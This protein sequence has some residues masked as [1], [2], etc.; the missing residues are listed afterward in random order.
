VFDIPLLFEGNRADEFDAVL[1]VSAPAEEQRE[2]ALAR[3]GMTVDKFEAILARQVPDADKCARADYVIP[4]GG[5]LDETRAAVTMA[6]DDLKR[7]AKAGL[8]T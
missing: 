1:V 4:T 5:S 8:H 2:R 7:Q 6:L 3:P